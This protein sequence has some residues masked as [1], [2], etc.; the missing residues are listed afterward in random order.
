MFD[1]NPFGV[2]AAL[3]IPAIAAAAFL[4]SWR[5][6]T[7]A[8]A[9]VVAL[10]WLGLWASGSRTALAAG[11]IGTAFV[12]Y[13]CTDRVIRTRDVSR[14]GL[15][16]GVAIVAVLLL[17]PLL[18]Q[19]LSDVG[20]WRRLVDSL[21]GLTLAELWNR[22]G[23]GLNAAQMIREFPGFGVGIGSFHHLVLDYSRMPSGGGLLPTDNAQNWYRHQLAEFGVVGS[24]GWIWWTLS[25]GW[26][27]LTARVPGQTGWA[28]GAIRG[29]L[30]A[31]ALI[32][33][34]GMPT[35]DVAVTMTF[36]TLAFWC[37]LLAG[38]PSQASVLRQASTGASIAV[39]LVAALC[40]A[41]TTYSAR[42]ELRVPARAARFGWPYSYG[43]YEPES[44]S[45]GGQF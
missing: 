2:I 22:N 21:P 25:F 6:R 1:A 8:V 43:W 44:G 39:W 23:Y 13:H 7:A 20:P 40:V 42:H 4:A 12:L 19:R 27:V 10:G 32:S 16:A 29:G 41:G 17:A 24:L 11:L 15:F 34:L 30:V 14:R 18:L 9:F 26:F 36:W 33:M 3:G 5:G 28:T 38:G 35:Q 31:I 37:S 45:D